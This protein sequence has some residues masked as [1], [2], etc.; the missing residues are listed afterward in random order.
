MD[1]TRTSGHIGLNTKD[2]YPETFGVCVLPHP[3]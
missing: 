1:D 3:Y 2:A